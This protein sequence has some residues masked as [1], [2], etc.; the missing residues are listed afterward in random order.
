MAERAFWPKSLGCPQKSGFNQPGGDENIIATTVQSGPQ[1]RRP[2]VSTIPSKVNFNLIL[3]AAGVQTLLD[4]YWIT[5]NQTGYFYLPDYTKPL[6]S[7]NV[8]VY[9][10]L[11]EPAIEKIGGRYWRASLSLNRLT[12][13]NGH[14]LL[15][16]REETN[17]LS[18]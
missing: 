13:V 17:Y 16:I 14:F 11:G 1:R 15:N 2:R 12:T 5:I 8:A 9:E 7:D 18:T 10:M 4:F 3:H 6:Y